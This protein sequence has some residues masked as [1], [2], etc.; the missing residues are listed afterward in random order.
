MNR[1]NAKDSKLGIC[2]QPIFMYSYI[3]FISHT[4]GS[5]IKRG[6]WPLL[7]FSYLDRGVMMAFLSWILKVTQKRR[8]VLCGRICHLAQ[9]TELPPPSSLSQTEMSWVC[10][11]AN[12]KTDN[13]CFIDKLLCQDC[14][15]KTP[16][17]ESWNKIIL[18]FHSS[19][20]WNAEQCVCACVCVPVYVLSLLSL[21]AGG[22]LP[23]VF[24]LSVLYTSLF[25][26]GHQ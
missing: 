4:E 6:L 20:S 21:P 8:A 18:F 2:L 22:P 23:C 11:A 5:V 9:L 13:Y 24:T 12:L 1:W 26:S 7:V 25:L 10:E 15:D 16:Q 17:T 3:F 14:G 19:G